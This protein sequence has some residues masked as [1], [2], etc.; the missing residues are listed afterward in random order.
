MKQP[1]FGT[2]FYTILL[3]RKKFETPKINVF[4]ANY[5]VVISHIYHNKNS[6][7]DCGRNFMWENFDLLL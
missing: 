4:N 3:R 1:K 7:V 6:F 5:I 2:S